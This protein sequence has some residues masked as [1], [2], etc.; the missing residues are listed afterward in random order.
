MPVI[1]SE[2]IADATARWIDQGNTIPKSKPRSILL[3]RLC[4]WCPVTLQP[5]TFHRYKLCKPCAQSY[6]RK[7]ITKHMLNLQA[8]NYL[9]YLELKADI[10]SD[11]VRHGA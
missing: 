1:T 6:K 11:G 9:Q 2:V 10:F 5:H 4:A 3:R 7:L 8:T